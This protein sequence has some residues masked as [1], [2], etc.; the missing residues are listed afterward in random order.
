MSRII[1]AL[2]LASS[3]CLAYQTTAFDRHAAVKSVADTERRVP[4]SGGAGELFD[5]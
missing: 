3:S 4:V 1:L 2:A 5:T